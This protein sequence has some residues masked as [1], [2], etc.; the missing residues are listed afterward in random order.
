MKTLIYFIFICLMFFSFKVKSQDLILYNNTKDTIKCKIIK[1]KV[2]FVEYKLANDTNVYRI[3]QEQYDY[4]VQNDKTVNNQQFITSDTIDSN[5]KHKEC[6]FLKKIVVGIGMGIDHGGIVGVKL[7]S[8]IY[9]VSLFA[10]VGYNLLEAGFN[11][12]IVVRLFPKKIFTPTLTGMYGYNAIIVVNDAKK[13]NKTYYGPSVGVGVEIRPRLKN[14]F[15]VGLII[16]FRSQQFEKDYD[17]LQQD[18]LIVIN[19]KPNDVL[20]SFGY[21]FVFK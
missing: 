20:L 3:Y 17:A 16:P 18:P 10:G 15:S 21:H 14:Y 2:K 6:K 4:Y 12:G 7:S 5:A 13:Y 11:V 19:Q 9:Y 1:D 8:P